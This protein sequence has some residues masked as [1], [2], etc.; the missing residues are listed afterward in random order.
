[1]YIIFLLCFLLTNR[2][3]FYIILFYDIIYDNELR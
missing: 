2:I 3:D 1:M